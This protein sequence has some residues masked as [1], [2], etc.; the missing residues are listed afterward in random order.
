MNV[1]NQAPDELRDW[2]GNDAWSTTPDR[3]PKSDCYQDDITGEYPPERETKEARRE[4]LTFNGD[5]QVWDIAPT[6]ECHKRTG[7]APIGGRWVDHNK[8]D[9]VN[10]GIRS[11]YVTQEFAGGKK[12]PELSAPTPPLEALRLILSDVATRPRGRRGPRT[13]GPRGARPARAFLS[14]RPSTSRRSGARS[15]R[16]SIALGRISGSKLRRWGGRVG[17]RGESSA[18]PLTILPFTSIPP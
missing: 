15:P 12:Q 6:A 17:G 13:E 16:S 1:N 2:D 14:S 9:N 18:A 10:P 3:K 4:E 11:R 8:D 7:K 5:W